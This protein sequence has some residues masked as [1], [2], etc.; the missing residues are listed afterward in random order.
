MIIPD[1]IHVLA[2]AE[3]VEPIARTGDRQREPLL[4]CSNTGGLP[5]SYKR[6]EH[7]VHPRG[8]LPALAD[9]NFI[10]VAQNKTV[11]NIRSVHRSFC[12]KVVDI[13]RRRTVL[14]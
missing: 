9:G 5:P 13:S 10:D 6:I 11:R 12:S 7:A 14:V 4:E 1:N 3:V 8:I 2:R